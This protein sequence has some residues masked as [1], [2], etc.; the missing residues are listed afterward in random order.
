[1]FIIKLSNSKL[2]LPVFETT[3]NI[4]NE[5]VSVLGTVS[6]HEFLSN[7]QNLIKLTVTDEV[8]QTTVFLVFI[9][10]GLRIT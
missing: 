9:F 1:M 6:A 2:K 3:E 8:L 4:Y 7:L 5:N 10:L